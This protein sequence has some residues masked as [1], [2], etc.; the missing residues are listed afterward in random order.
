MR[1]DEPSK[2]LRSKPLF[3]EEHPRLFAGEILKKVEESEAQCE[4]HHDGERICVA[5]IIRRSDDTVVITHEA[6]GLPHLDQGRRDTTLYLTHRRVGRSSRILFMCPNCNAAVASLALAG[7]RWACRSCQD[8]RYSSQDPR[9]GSST[10]KKLNRIRELRQATAGGKPHNAWTTRHRRHVEEHHALTATYDMRAAVQ[11]KGTRAIIGPLWGLPS[12]A[13]GGALDETAPNMRSGRLSYLEAFPTLISTAVR[14]ARSTGKRLCVWRDPKGAVIGGAEVD[15]S[16]ASSLCVRYAVQ[17]NRH[18]DG[19]SGAL[20]LGVV[21]KGSEANN[22]RA[23]FV[24][25]PCRHARTSLM[26]V[27]QRWACRAC[28]GLQYRTALIPAAARRAEKYRKLRT[29]FAKL[30]QRGVAKARG[31]KLDGRLAEAMRA[32]G[33]FP[34]PATSR[35]YEYRLTSEWLAETFSEEG[36][37]DHLCVLEEKQ[38]ARQSPDEKE[39]A[40]YETSSSISNHAPVEGRFESVRSIAHKLTGKPLFSQESLESFADRALKSLFDYHIRQVESGRRE[41]C[42]LGLIR[43]LSREARLEPIVVTSGWSPSVEPDAVPQRGDLGV[44]HRVTHEL[45]TVSAGYTGAEELWKCFPSSQR[46][47]RL[48]GSVRYGCIV[49]TARVPREDIHR[50]H[51]ILEH[52]LP[53]LQATIAELNAQVEE[54]NE[55]LP[56]RVERMLDARTSLIAERGEVVSMLRKLNS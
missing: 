20:S 54:Y 48:R 3:I 47:H 34:H 22:K 16:S 53:V 52:A 18:Q 45:G 26:L 51:G 13:H 39:R 41:Y 33:P 29:E 19:A 12:A 17:R 42:K 23:L 21:F 15:W 32:A 24:C 43:L 38:S 10:F 4:W 44:P 5:R 35:N 55:T 40:M 36:F 2:R 25:P 1:A 56:A 30:S 14:N 6:I 27:G 46:A 50:I 37:Y 31:Q 9:Y 49:L 8:L 28:H 7:A 11:A